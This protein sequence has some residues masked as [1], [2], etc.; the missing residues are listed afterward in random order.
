MGKVSSVRRNTGNNVESSGS[1][2]YVQKATK[3]IANVKRVPRTTSNL[4]NTYTHD[5]VGINLDEEHNDFLLV[6][7]LKAKEL[8]ELNASSEKVKS[9]NV[10]QD[11]NAHD[12]QRVDFESLLRNVQIE[13]N[14][15]H[16]VSLQGKIE[17]SNSNSIL[18]EKRKNESFEK[19]KHDLT[20]QSSVQINI[21]SLLR[22]ECESLKE[23]FKKQEDKYLDD[24][25]R[26]E[27]KLKDPDRIYDARRFDGVI[28]YKTSINGLNFDYGHEKETQEY[29]YT[30]VK[31]INDHLRQCAN[32]FQQEITKEVKEMID[33][34]DSM[35]SEL[36]ETLSQNIENLVMYSCVENKNENVRKE[37][38]KLLTESN[39]VQE[40][41]LNHIKILENDFQRCQAQS[42][43]FELNLQHKKE[44]YVFKNSWISKAKKLDDA[45]Y[46]YNFKFIGRIRAL[47]E[48][49]RDLDVEN[50]QEESQGQLQCNHPIDC[51][52]IEPG[53]FDV[54]IG[55]NRLTRYHAMIIFDKKSVHIPLDDETLTIRSNRSDGYASIVA[56]KKNCLIGLIC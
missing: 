29:F 51:I 27:A 10:K 5:E 11:N 39:D 19:E 21:I 12:Q 23:T 33:I 45:Q 50:K 24:I 41:L 3:D 47:E 26:L 37:N 52:P 49:T 36:D 9:D 55:V 14:K 56:S 6:D 8:Q 32:D 15:T 38:E 20:L 44:K 42:I 22:Q 1:A 13:S 16:K 46:L 48:E 17:R 30:E 31:L 4:G 28:K 2:A 18:V 35:E 54:I 40:S 34:F 7:V 25:L 43:A 53:S